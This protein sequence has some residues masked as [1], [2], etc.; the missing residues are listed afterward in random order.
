MNAKTPGR[1]ERHS[2][3]RL[4]V[5]AFMNW[6]VL[7]ACTAGCTHTLAERLVRAPNLPSELRG[8]DS[9]A[10]GVAEIGV[11]RQLRIAVG[12]RAATLSVWIIDPTRAK[13]SIQLVP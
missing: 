13:E 8:G 3:W 2:S 10:A 11:S 5:L 9:A 4:G 1:Q 6:F 7:F 12:P